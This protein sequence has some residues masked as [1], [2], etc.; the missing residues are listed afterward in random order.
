[1]ER[2]H[3]PHVAHDVDRLRR[4]DSMPYGVL[5]D[6]VLV[7]LVAADMVAKPFLT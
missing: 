4:H 6:I 3:S 7:L 2:V 1:M 5:A